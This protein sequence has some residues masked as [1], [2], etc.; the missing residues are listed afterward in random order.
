M[1][2]QNLSE[3]PPIPNKLYY[4][5]GE[6]G[7]YCKV[8]AY[9]LR[10]W[11]QEFPQLKPK[12]RGNRRYYLYKD[13]LLIRRIKDLLYNQ[14]FTIDGARA[15]LANANNLNTTFQH[16][17]E[18]IKNSIHGLEQILAELRIETSGA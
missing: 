10:Y 1:Q 7:K 13:I 4:N 6:V 16:T 5:I 11:E 14:G 17:K 3:L 2:E 15:Q 18:F 12:R 9:V 8:K